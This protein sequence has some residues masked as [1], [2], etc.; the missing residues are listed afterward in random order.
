VPVAKTTLGPVEGAEREG[1]LR[2][3]GIP[4]AKPPVDE[5]RFRPPQPADPWDGVRPAT[6]FGHT[7]LQN[8]MGIEVLFGGQPEPVSE[9]CLYLNVWTPALDDAERP[10]MV[11]IHGGAFVMGSGSSTMYDGASFARRGDVV[12]VSLNYRLGEIGYSHLAHLDESYAGS[13]NCGVLDQVAALEWVRAN[14]ANFGGDPDNVTIFGE[15]AGGMSVGTLLGTPA[16]KGLFH[17]AIP[18]SGA[19]HNSLPAKLAAEVTDE[20]MTRLNVRTV[21]ELV[22]VPGDQLLKQRADLLAETFGDPDRTMTGGALPWE[23]VHDGTVLPDPPLD[24]VRAGLNADVP[25]LVGTTN[26]EWKLFSLVVPGGEMTEKKVVARASRL[27][28]DGAAFVEGYRGG[29]GELPPAELF[30]RMATD[31]VFRIPAI[32]LAEAQLRHTPAV[33]M[34]RFDW[35]SRA[36]G[37]ALGACHAIELPFVFH[38]VDRPGMAMFLGDGPPPTELADQVQDAWVAFARNGDPNTTAL[39]DWP[40]YDESRRATMQ[41]AEPCRLLDD[42]QA[43]TRRLWDHV[44]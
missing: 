14:I 44:R 18:Q 19:A 36:F 41:L 40:P 43:T 30:D 10:V 31:Y 22:A 21:A 20:L 32:R 9:D 29:G 8:P 5:L 34:Y 3:A 27:V 23:P 37:G 4:F 35:R 1:V 7:C 28:G 38:N 42:P 12:F 13:G 25:L 17:K 39:P 15:S 16:A 6:S 26:E 33:W 24:A 11:W 2:F